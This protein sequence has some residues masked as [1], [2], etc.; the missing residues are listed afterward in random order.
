[1]LSHDVDSLTVALLSNALV[2]VTVLD[3]VNEYIESLPQKVNLDYFSKSSPTIDK[4]DKAILS[5]LYNML[6]HTRAC[7]I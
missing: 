6:E 1:V 4:V 5:T 3:P 2:G 7:E